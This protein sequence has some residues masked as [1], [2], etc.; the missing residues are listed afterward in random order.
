MRFF[1]FH[2]RSIPSVVRKWCKMIGCIVGGCLMYTAL[3]CIVLQLI[4]FICISL[5]F[6]AH[7]GRK[8]NCKCTSPSN[9]L[10]CAVINRSAQKKSKIFY[11]PISG[12]G[13]HIGDCRKNHIKEGNFTFCDA[14]HGVTR[15][16]TFKSCSVFTLF[17]VHWCSV[18]TMSW[19]L[20][21]DRWL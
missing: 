18:F 11:W 3:H 5:I 14:C 19:R 17:T 20:I 7:S 1:L 13:S 16:K 12:L 4:I 15:N 2:D 9:C 10:Q 21:D 8:K 6:P